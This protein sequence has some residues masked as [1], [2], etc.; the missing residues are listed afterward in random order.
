MKIIS[1]YNV[2]IIGGGP[3]GIAAGIYAKYDNNNPIILE[4]KNLAWIPESHINLL[5]RV[6]GLPGL[7][8]RVGG[9]ELKKM[10]IDSLNEMDVKY[11]EHTLV[12]SIA[13][14]K[15]GEF[16]IRTDTGELYRSKVAIVCTGTT[17]KRLNCKG[18][19]KFKNNVHYFAYND[20]QQYLKSAEKSVIVFGSRNSGATAAIY[21]ARKG[22]KVT[23]VE[24]KDSV[25]AKDKHTKHFEPLG[26]KVITGA[27]VI[28]LNGDTTLESI[29]ILAAGE[30]KQ[31]QACGLYCYIG[32]IPN[33]KLLNK[34]GL[35][36]GSEGYFHTDFFQQ[37][38][39]PGLFV[40]GDI[41]GDLKHIVAS[42]G[43]GA[44][45]A[46]NANKFLHSVTT[47]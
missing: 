23:I 37:S 17:P 9:T 21:L 12:E 1:R 39:V 20:F 24:L 30:T 7:V 3:A 10:Y 32:V 25:Q 35:E 13:Q 46:Y 6:E 36:R 27:T 15:T 44:K 43:Q 41:C 18:L 26:I 29:T 2:V 4:A 22:L 34:F 38:N 42:S 8:N 14:T 28:S 40:A 47:G 19:I 5:G 31:V 45:A 16:E 33:D 11:R